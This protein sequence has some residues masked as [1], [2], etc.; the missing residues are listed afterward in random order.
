MNSEGDPMSFGIDQSLDESRR[1]GSALRAMAWMAASGLV[2]G[3]ANA[4]LRTMALQ[5]SAYQTMAMQYAAMLVLFVPVVVHRG[6]AAFLPRNMR[7][8]LLRGGLHWVATIV[9]LI[10]LAHITLAEATAIGFTAPLFVMA[11]ASLLLKE[12]LRWD[13][14]TAAFAGLCGVLVVVAP[15]LTGG[16]GTYSFLM[17]FSTLV[18]SYAYL[19]TKQLTSIESAWT[20]VLWQSLVVAICS[21]PLALLRWQPAPPELWIAAAITAALTMAGQY[22]LAK[23]FAA[24]DMSV[25]QPVSYVNLVWACLF[26][27]MFFGDRVQQ[28]TLAG[29]AIIVIATIWLARREVSR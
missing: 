21:V 7:G 28:A 24:A 1:P 11:G 3:L 12:R 27:W 5:Q 10:A 20:I 14:A 25:S 9:W 6:L 29:G 18:Y 26:G 22:S 16:G 2:F 4:V 8:V 19:V 13:R 23:S 15:R 17:F